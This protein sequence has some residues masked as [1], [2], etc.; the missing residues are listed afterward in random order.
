MRRTK[1]KCL[2][3]CLKRC[4]RG[5]QSHCFQR[6]QQEQTLGWTN[7]IGYIALPASKP[8]GVKPPHIMLRNGRTT[9]SQD[10]TSK[11]STIVG[12]A[13]YLTGSPSRFSEQT[14]SATCPQRYLFRSQVHS[15]EIAR[16]CCAPQRLAVLRKGKCRDVSHQRPSRPAHNSL[17][18]HVTGIR[19]DRPEKNLFVP[20]SREQVV[21]RVAAFDVP[22]EFRSGS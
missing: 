12:D 16:G 21:A 5:E 14:R 3:R 11:Q 6:M 20:G 2:C 19:V 13:I 7:S 18:H 8:M 10:Y 17:L 15:H 1:E 4:S 9:H 22:V